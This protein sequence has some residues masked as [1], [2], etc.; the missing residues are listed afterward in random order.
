M[1][2][3]RTSQAGAGGAE[4]ALVTGASS[5]IGRA[6]AQALVG[7]GFTVYAGA[8]R[9]ET[10]HDLVGAVPVTLDVTDE[11]SM[12]AAV[13]RAQATRGRVSVLVNAAGLGI[14]GAME[15]LDLDVLRHEFEVNVFGM[16]RMSQLV[17]PAMRAAGGGRIVNVG[18]VGGLFTAPGAGAYHMSKFAV[19]ALS[20]ALRMETKRFGVQVALLEPTGVR[21]TP[22]I[23]KQLATLPDSGAHSPYAAMYEQ[24]RVSIPK[25]FE[26]GSRA[27][28]TPEAVAK[29]V[30][31]AATARRAKS[32]Y[33]VGTA[34]RVLRSTRRHLP[35]RAFDAVS[36]RQ[37]P[38]T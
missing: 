7:A 17:L 35:D 24:M 25:L 21:D 37:F 5:G 27:V 36:M 1:D 32:R 3:S 20:D 16:L 18:S 15:E 8:R 30:V 26:D 38:N 11:E 28:V 13:K 23:G 4:V 22:F 19:E 29:V 6:C 31:Q 34:A 33:L 10:V 9:V 14:S 12:A 2:S